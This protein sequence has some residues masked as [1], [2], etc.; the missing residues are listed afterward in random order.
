MSMKTLLA[1]IVL[2]LAPQD[3]PMAT[4]AIG[5]PAPD[6]K[7]PGVDGK[8]YT[9]A[10]FASSKLFVVVFMSNH[11]PT[12][13][14]YEDRLKQLVVDYKAKGVAFVA[15]QPNSQKGLRLDEMGYT[16]VGDTFE[17]M[18]IR[19]KDKQFNFPYIDD[20][21]TQKVSR[22]Y[23]CKATP[24]AFL[25]DDSRRLRYGGRIDDSEPP[26]N[27][28]VSDLRNALDA[29]LA[30][31]DVPVPMTKPFGCSTKWAS[32]E[33]SVRK[34]METLAAE[35]VTVA[36]VESAGLGALRT[37]DAGKLRLVSYWSV[38]EA[39][40]LPGLVEINRMYR[41]RAFEMVTVAVSPPEK[42]A[43]VEKLLKDAQCSAKNLLLANKEGD[44][45]VPSTV[46]YNAEG[47][48]LYKK[49]GKIDTLELKRAIVDTLGR[50][51]DTKK[52]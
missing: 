23:G 34:Y 20:G 31:K 32:K 50:M 12:A 17:D 52:K 44:F 1:A 46:L 41:R 18:K 29:L 30:G 40:N 5:D 43:D 21:D 10:D 24:H 36:A 35:P 27:V 15:I 9:L 51:M 6:F 7:L 3:P 28:K 33:D 37:N 11:C 42:K 25:F 19:A 48:V 16:E 26:E 47:K 2:L 45:D 39:G 49:S 22:A 4:L 14:A 8:T 13:Q 38:A